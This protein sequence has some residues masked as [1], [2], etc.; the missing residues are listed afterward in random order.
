MS[1]VDF[2]HFQEV[3]QNAAKKY[4]PGRFNGWFH[5]WP[6]FR[7]ISVHTKSSSSSL[8]QGNRDGFCW[9]SAACCCCWAAGQSGDSPKDSQAVNGPTSSR[10]TTSEHGD[11]HISSVSR[12]NQRAHLKIWS[13]GSVPRPVDLHYF[14]SATWRRDFVVTILLLLFLLIL[15]NCDFEV[16]LLLVSDSFRLVYSSF[17]VSISYFENF[18][19]DLM[20]IIA[21]V[22][23]L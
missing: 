15:H 19:I 20:R 1:W 2:R 23:I 6:R 13:E 21:L 4:F 5:V 14:I 10:D 3:H 22:F 12:Q 18:P 8:Q 16:V 7:R 11:D 9:T 17:V